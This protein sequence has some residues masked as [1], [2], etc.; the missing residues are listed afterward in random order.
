MFLLSAFGCMSHI[1]S[2]RHLQVRLASI[3]RYAE[4]DEPSRAKISAALSQLAQDVSASDGPYVEG[5]EP[6]D[7]EIRRMT[8][9]ARA[10]GEGT[11]VKLRDGSWGVKL[12]T[13]ARS[14]DS[15][16]VRKKSGQTA[17]VTLG[18]LVWS[19]ES[20]AWLF[21][22]GSSGSSSSRSR[23]RYECEE[24]GEYVLPGTECWETGIIH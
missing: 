23:G 16:V 8:K 4:G 20:D 2:P 6:S 7:A 22:V 19:N 10:G 12:T 9:R 14:G 3:L 13:R 15:V 1:Q 11:W 24:C 18:R 5:P 21:T 17:T